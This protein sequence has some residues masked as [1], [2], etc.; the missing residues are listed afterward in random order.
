[1]RLGAW[2]VETLEVEIDLHQRLAG[3]VDRAPAGETALVERTGQS[4]DQ[5][6]RAVEPH[7]S[8]GRQRRVQR[9]RRLQRELDRN[10]L[11]LDR[12]Q[13]HGCLD[14]VLHRRAACARGAR[15]L[16]LA[17]G[18]EGRLGVDGVD[19]ALQLV[20]RIGEGDRAVD[21]CDAVDLHVALARGRRRL[22]GYLRG[23]AM[24][25]AQQ[26]H[27]EHRL[28]DDEFGD[29]RMAR[30]RARQRHIGLQ[31]ADRDLV[32]AFTVLRL[33]QGQVVHGDVE[34]RPQADPGRAGNRQAIAGFALD[35]L[36]DGGGQKA[37]GDSDDHHKREDDDD[38]SNGC[39]YEFQCSHLD[40]PGQRGAR[41][42]RRSSPAG[43][44]F[45]SL[46]RKGDSAQK[47]PKII[48][49]SCKVM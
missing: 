49:S 8:L 20:V 14:V 25:L 38:G 42:V 1:M 44:G 10:V 18:V 32:G 6:H 24:A 16:D 48:R 12:R 35:P 11:P 41:P 40:G 47:T 28:G 5:H 15:K 9:A 21:D 36:L 33:L 7:L 46:S 43:A 3:D 31:R 2:N 29:F 19:P 45:S 17:I 26:R 23:D 13:R 4:V 37:G 30:P 34:R 22:V 39:P 27:I